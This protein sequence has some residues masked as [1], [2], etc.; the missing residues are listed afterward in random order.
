[1]DDAFKWVEKN[2]ITTESQYPYNARTQKCKNNT[3]GFKIKGH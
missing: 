2:G 1:M 3:G